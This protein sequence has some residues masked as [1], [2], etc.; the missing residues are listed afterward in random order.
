MSFYLCPCCSEKWIEVS[1]F[2]DG[3]CGSCL[4]NNEG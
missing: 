3:A 1:D 2:D 4:V